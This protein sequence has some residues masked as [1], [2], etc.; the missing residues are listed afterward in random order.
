MAI[1]LERQK[2]E[3]E[4]LFRYW[5]NVPPVKMVNAEIQK[6]EG[7]DIRGKILKVLRNGIPDNFLLDGNSLTKRHVLTAQEIRSYLEKEENLKIKINSLY[8]HLGILEEYNI[9]TIVNAILQGRHRVAYYGRTSRIIVYGP[10]DT[11]EN[12]EQD[13]EEFL[14]LLKKINP[15]A[16]NEYKKLKS[17]HFNKIHQER[18][19]NLA[20]WISQYEKEIS[21]E[22]LD[23]YKIMSF[24]YV[25]D[26]LHP[27]YN[28]FFSDLYQQLNVQ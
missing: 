18:A 15:S 1:K 4:R 23:V 7:H 21:E 5:Q 3:R 16:H 11:C 10:C 13:F 17:E 24:L 2:R 20:S 25:I 8:F 14:K 12:Y 26:T 9:I 6:V 28:E 22:N 27:S 19:T